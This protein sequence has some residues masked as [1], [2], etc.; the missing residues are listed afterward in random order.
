MV[1]GMSLNVPNSI[2]MSNEYM[3]TITR[4]YPLVFVTKKLPKGEAGVISLEGNDQIDMVA[5]RAPVKKVL[6]SYNENAAHNRGDE[7]PRK[8]IFRLLSYGVL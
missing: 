3:F 4:I 2:R 7:C 6:E 1:A 5:S 8:V